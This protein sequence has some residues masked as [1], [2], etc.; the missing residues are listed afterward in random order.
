MAVNP[1]KLLR[2]YEGKLKQL[3]NNVQSIT[4]IIIELYELMRTHYDSRYGDPRHLVHFRYGVYS[5]RKED[6]M[7]A[8]ILRRVPPTEHFFIEFGVGALQSNTLSLLLQGWRG[9]WVDGNGEEI[10]LIRKLYHRQIDRGQLRAEFELITAENIN[11]LFMEAKVPAEPD[12]LSIDIDGNDY[13]VWKAIKCRPRIV[14]IEYNAF[15]GPSIDCRA[16]YD[17][18]WQWRFNRAF[19]SSLKAL[20]LLGKAKGYCLV[21]CDLSGVNAFFVR[22]DLVDDRFVGPYTSE[23]HFE[24]AKYFLRYYPGH[25]PSYQEVETFFQ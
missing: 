10:A 7:I 23:A 24:S 14:V 15:L 4:Y 8:E 6:G 11:E 20:E 1:F 19:G 9:L 21:G 12:L 3:Y 13:W 17:P 16:P 22:E 25:D 2:R 18:R 5:Q